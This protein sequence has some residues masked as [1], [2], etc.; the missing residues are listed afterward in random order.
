MQK[1]KLHF[2]FSFSGWGCVISN[3][4]FLIHLQTPCE[5]EDLV[6]RPAGEE[7]GGEEHDGQPEHHGKVVADAVDDG[8]GDGVD[9]DLDCGLH[10]EKRQQLVAERKKSQPTKVFKVLVE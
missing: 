1:I 10:M 3:C 4:V 5:E 6:A 7:E 9:E 8:A 2:L